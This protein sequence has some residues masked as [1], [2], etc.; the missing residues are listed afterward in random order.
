LIG[1]ALYAAQCGEEYPSVKAL[2]GFGGRGILEILAP[3]ERRRLSSG[4]YG[5]L[6][7]CHLRSACFSEEVEERKSS[8]G[9]PLQSGTIRKTELR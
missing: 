6:L 2:K 3:Y 1:Q 4:V 9:S 5:P 7:R 8:S